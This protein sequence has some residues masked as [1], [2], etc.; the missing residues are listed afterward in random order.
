VLELVR[1]SPDFVSML[2]LTCAS[3][4]PV[5]YDAF[6]PGSPGLQR[7]LRSNG[8][9]RIARYVPLNALRLE[10]NPAWR[11]VS[12]PVRR[13]Y[14][15]EI[16]ITVADAGVGDVAARIDAG[17]ADLPWGS[18][19]AVPLHEPVDDGAALSYALDPY[20][21]F[22]LAG[23]VPPL[24]DVRVRRAIA[25]AVDRAALAE[26][27]RRFAPGVDVRLATSIVPPNNDGHHAVPSGDAAA[28]PARARGL[29]DDAGYRTG[30][31]LTAA[32]RDRDAGLEVARSYAADLEAV[33][34]SVRLVEFDAA[35]DP[36]GARW[37]LTA[38]S[39]SADWLYL[40]ARVFLQPL[41][42]TGAPGNV[43]RY[44]NPE[45]DGL[46]RR[47]LEAAVDSAPR[48]AAAWRDVERRVLE[49]VAVVPLLF[50]APP[51]PRKRSAR[52]RDASPVP[53]IGYAYDLS[54][55]WVD[56]PEDDG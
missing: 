38:W 16:E 23:G 2:A 32:Y 50:R 26:L 11:R 1:P 20:L 48:A 52:V 14:V 41:F 18:P 24:R 3:A 39:W 49:D 12:D 9:Y 51:V 31:A 43:G 30:L 6:V 28:D 56:S 47:A 35:A 13:R 36:P 8:P 27:Y 42:E 4:A 44:V 54:T 17:A 40:N 25:A 37:D 19:H 29:L 10:P 7:H 45:V 34:I 21:V 53:A 15:E 46:I 55:L 33:G 5:E 22:N